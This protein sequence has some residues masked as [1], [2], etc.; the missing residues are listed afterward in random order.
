V[1]ISKFAVFFL[2]EGVICLVVNFVGILIS[3]KL[4]LS[5]EERWTLVADF[6]NTEIVPLFM[7]CELCLRLY[8]CERIELSI[9]T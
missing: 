3:M 4:P 6:S 5:Y 1:R 2:T 8:G 7:Q 9:H